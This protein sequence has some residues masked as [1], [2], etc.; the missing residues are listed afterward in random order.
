MLYDVRLTI[1]YN[2]AAASDRTR[3]LLRLL[4]ADVAG[5]QRVLSRQLTISP[6]PDERRDGI[7]F[8]RNT[9]SA[10]AWHRPIAS[11]SLSLEA[12]IDRPDVAPRLD[13]STSFEALRADIDAHA[14][15]APDAPHHF[16]TSS[17]LVTLTP[18]MTDYARGCVQP[19]MTA[20]EVVEA[21]GGALHRD[22]RFD[23]DA[24]D[25]D[26]PPE[27]AFQNRHGVCQDFAH[28]M[29]AAL[30]GVGIPAGYVSGFL[31]TFPPP[32]QPRLEGAD[33]MHAWVRAWVG[34]KTG[35]IEFDPT[36]DQYAGHDYITVGYGRDYGDVAPV[37]GALRS[38]GAQT[39]QQAVD[40]VPLDTP[41][42][43]PDTQPTE[44]GMDVQ[45]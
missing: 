38:A 28:I 2:Y 11:L 16:A 30:R 10:V 31:R 21:V 43:T 20:L 4:P 1:D 27:V 35:W 32:G 14:N 29:I 39:S 8:F 7:D 9:I 25:V 15:L 12:R 24:T 3:N 19:G 36:N 44:N 42:E 13:F 6:L 5:V 34:A 17:P 45:A 41:A 33:A 18:E 23:P 26:T 22:M 37:R 40:V